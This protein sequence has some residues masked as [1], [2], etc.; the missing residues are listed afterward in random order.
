MK[1]QIVLQDWAGNILFEGHYKDKDVD[2]VLDANRC[3]CDYTPDCEKCEETGYIGDF[4]AY[5][6]DENDTR[7]IYEYINY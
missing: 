5:W 6:Q 3:D 1:N 4:E 2:R 7:N